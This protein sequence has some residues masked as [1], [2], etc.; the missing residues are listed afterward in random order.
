MAKK[1][2]EK[3]DEGV[4]V[5]EG[6]FS[7]DSRR[8]VEVLR[9]RQLQHAGRVTPLL[10][11][12]LAVLSK[13]TRVV[14]VWE[15][16]RFEARFDGLP[17]P[18]VLMARPYDAFL[19][20][21]KGTRLMSQFG[22]ALL[23]LAQPDVTV[24]VVSG[25]FDSRKAIYLEGPGA[26][27]PAPQKDGLDET[28]VRA[29]WTSAGSPEAGHPATWD[30]PSLT[31]YLTATPIPV[32]IGHYGKVSVVAPWARRYGKD[33]WSGDVGGLRCGMRVLPHPEERTL[34]SFS[35]DGVT[36]E[37]EDPKGLPLP[38]E[39]W[40]DAPEAPLNASLDRFVKGPERDRA[41]AAVWKALRAAYIDAMERHA[42]RMKLVGRMLE[43]DQN[44]RWRWDEMMGGRVSPVLP[45]G[46][47]VFGASLFSRPSGDKALLDEVALWSL[48]W[49]AAAKAASVRLAPD[50]KALVAPLAKVPMD[51]D[52]AW[53]PVAG[54]PL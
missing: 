38:V 28:V 52:D 50:L 6:G 9:A 46:R 4:F 18:D 12:R 41:R 47:R 33:A 39:G 36:V 14:L 23:H 1:R 45:G 37:A 54:R 17:L 51:F 5:E 8:A 29:F 40:V 48:A 19:G 16:G 21:M 15:P 53:R 26:A 34:L 24:E 32:T 44:L 2:E 7:V 30:L 3:P 31:E 22:P 11:V 20:T 27:P 35:V 10:W 49:K 43:R 25:E 42:R 13:A